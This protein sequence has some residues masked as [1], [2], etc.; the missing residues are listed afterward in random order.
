M[1]E[2]YVVLDLEMTGLS[3]R[4]DRII[5][6]GLIKVKNH[7]VAEE[8][9]TLI[10]PGIKLPEKATEITGITDEMLVDK[11]RIQDKIVD[12]IDFLRGEV[13]IG[14][15]L[16]MDFAF[17]MQECY[18]CGIYSSVRMERWKGIDTLEI[19]KN[20]YLQSSQRSLLELCRHYGD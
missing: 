8:F 4:Y 7:R 12:V 11:V 6:I 2:N 19:A 20:V 1:L 10:Y 15:N 18:R 17:L 3:P 9:A 13:L 5:E 16:Q 14:H